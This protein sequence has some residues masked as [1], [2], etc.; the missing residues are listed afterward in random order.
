MSNESSGY[1]WP[2]TLLGR[3]GLRRQRD[4]YYSGGDDHVRN[5]YRWFLTLLGRPGLR[6]QRVNIYSGDDNYDT[7]GYVALIQPADILGMVVPSKLITLRGGSVLAGL[8]VDEAVRNPY[9]CIKLD[10]PCAII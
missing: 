9:G 1:C 8:P 3:P 7:I 4:S 6:H 2:L 10:T 5:G